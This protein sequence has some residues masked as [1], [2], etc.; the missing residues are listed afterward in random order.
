MQPAV[1]LAPAGVIGPVTQAALSDVLRAERARDIARGILFAKRVRD[2][3]E[4][5]DALVATTTGEGYRGAGVE[6]VQ[7]FLANL[8]FFPADSVNG[9]FG[10]LTRQAVVAYQ[11]SRGVLPSAG[12][13][14]AGTVGPVTLKRLQREQFEHAYATVRGY[15]WDAL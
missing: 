11:L 3:L 1:Y 5:N 4:E 13:Q 2:R 15:G 9:T 8:G 7:R 12:A 10:P 14:G 6:S